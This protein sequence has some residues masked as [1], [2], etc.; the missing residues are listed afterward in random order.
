MNRQP[1]LVAVKSNGRG[2]RRRRRLAAL[3]SPAAAAAAAASCLAAL[4]L[5]PGHSSAI[6]AAFAL[7]AGSSCSGGGSGGG[8][9]GGGS[10][11][12]CFVGAARAGRLRPRPIRGQGSGSVRAVIASPRSDRGSRGASNGSPT[13]LLAARG[14]GNSRT[15]S[16][17]GDLSGE[18]NC[19]NTAWGN[20]GAAAQGGGGLAEAA[21]AA[22]VDEK[23]VSYV[24]STRLRLSM[25]T[26][27]L[28]TSGGGAVRAATRA[29]GATA[30]AAIATTTAAAVAAAT[31]AESRGEDQ[32]AAAATSP[33]NLTKL[34]VSELKALYRQGGGKPGA[35]RKAEL[36][37][38]L[39][40]SLD[41]GR[42]SPDPG[43]SEAVGP[44]GPAAAE[45]LRAE[46]GTPPAVGT[47]V[48][49]Q[50]SSNPNGPENGPENSDGLENPEGSEGPEV[51]FMDNDLLAPYNAD[52]A[53]VGARV[54]VEEG[55]E[56]RGAATG[57]GAVSKSVAAGG[58]GASGIVVDLPP[59]AV[60]ERSVA[61]YEG[62]G[63]AAAVAGDV[64]ASGPSAVVAAARARGA[65]AAA[66]SARVAAGGR[67]R[68]MAE[69]RRHTDAVRSKAANGWSQSAEGL[70]QEKQRQDGGMWPAKG[71]LP[72]T[73]VPLQGNGGRNGPGAGIGARAG[74]G[75]GAGVG[76]GLGAG[77]GSEVG[78]GAATPVKRGAGGSIPIPGY[79]DVPRQPAHMMM[80]SAPR[81]RRA[82]GQGNGGKE[83]DHQTGG[84]KTWRAD[85]PR[86]RR[87]GGRPRLMPAMPNPWSR[88]GVGGAAEGLPE[89]GD[90]VEAFL[91]DVMM[92][93][94]DSKERE[95]SG[96]AVFDR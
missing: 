19:R 1:P 10:S 49:L 13:L 44:P 95:P 8:G 28:D 84:G 81:G 52:G 61:G 80:G 82:E 76:V 55:V 4:I 33:E 25:S 6:A 16:L 50:V 38:R 14:G 57:A 17:S 89:E 42:G 67:S 11:P 34:K 30:V 40:R 85:G 7:S 60:R 75:V 68:A 88:G 51:L 45:S 92:Q 47:D 41:E 26:A 27:A 46:G 48:S 53:G 70:E 24:R 91:E 63:E 39:T 31:P 79:G 90:V 93:S 36:V 35:L 12:A 94:S 74:A 65:A 15:G 62:K 64:L 3:S 29:A 73:G 37:E 2:R 5:K 86:V 32:E 77:L 66:A 20:A 43:E 59:F 71:S 21:A 9:G 58:P 23:R 96:D 72:L 83:A 87:D 56:V 22:P 78:V 69:V 54:E 18:A